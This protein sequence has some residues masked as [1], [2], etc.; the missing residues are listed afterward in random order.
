MS[1]VPLHDED[2]GVI[3]SLHCHDKHGENLLP[4]NAEYCE[5]LWA[6]YNDH[7]FGTL[8]NSTFGL[9]PAGR[10]PG[11]YRLGE[12][13]SAGAIP[14]FVGRDMVPPFREKFD[15][16]SFSFS[17]AP[18][19]VGPEM[20]ATLRAVPQA[21]LE[22]MQVGNLLY[23]SYKKRIFN[24][25]WLKGLPLCC[26]YYRMFLPRSFQGE[27]VRKE[28]QSC[29]CSALPPYFTGFRLRVRPSPIPSRMTSSSPMKTFSST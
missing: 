29:V 5:S 6:R 2:R 24:V 25:W 12:V 4:E 22:D 23:G 1:L 3:T 19:R 16:P 27:E 11:T 13:M 26:T 28:R 14:V 8:M 17:F 7:D 15:W 20:M 21:D 10:S 18:D 9:V